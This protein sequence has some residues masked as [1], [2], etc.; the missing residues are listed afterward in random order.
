MTKR[1]IKKKPVT[2]TLVIFVII[3]GIFIILNNRENSNESNINFEFNFDK[4]MTLA[5]NRYKSYK[6]CMQNEEYA[7]N[8]YSPSLNTLISNLSSLYKTSPDRV[9]FIYENFETGFSLT[10]NYNYSYYAVSTTKLPTAL[11]IYKLADGSADNS[12]IKINLNEKLTYTRNYSSSIIRKVQKHPFGTQFTVGE[13]LEY[14]IRYSDNSAHL[15]L[16]DRVGKENLQNYWKSV[17]YTMPNLNDYFGGITPQGAKIY[18]NE[19]YKYYL[20]GATNGKK[21]IEDMKASNNLDVI[22]NGNNEYKI[23]HKYGNHDINYHDIS[24][25]FDEHPYTLSILSNKGLSSDKKSFFQK[26]HSLINEINDL[27]WNEKTEYCREKILSND[28]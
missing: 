25:V 27:Y 24:I 1:K 8:N 7:Q 20:S 11:Y 28:Q 13:L 5:S 10:H 19:V 18:L 17:G 4:I 22:Y 26:T 21:L 3:F 23:A 15:M 14:S 6:D 12:T 2:I 9:S 16:M